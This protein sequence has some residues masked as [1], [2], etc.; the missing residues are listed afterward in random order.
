[1]NDQTVG[2]TE[3]LSE[4]LNVPQVD[5]SDHKIP[6]RLISLIPCDFA[7]K[8]RCVPFK[9]MGKTLQV[10]MA[11]PTNISV[12]DDLKFMTGYE[13]EPLITSETALESAIERYYGD[14]QSLAKAMEDMREEELELVEDKEEEEID[15]QKLHIAV[16]E[17]PVV[18]FVDSL[19][20]DA[21]RKGASDIHI[22]PYESFLRVRTR[23]DGVLYELPSPPAKL[24]NA[25][26]SRVK[27]MANLDLAER[28]VPQDGHIKMKLAAKTIDLRV[29]TL[30]TI[31]GEKV[32]MRILDRTAISLD[33][34][35][36]GFEEQG[37][38]NFLTA[39]Q[40]PYG[41]VLVTGPTGSGK[42]TTLYSALS[43]INTPKTN[44]MT[45]EDPIEYNFAG[46]NQL[47]VKENIGLTFS[48]AL[49]AFLRQD[50]DIIMVGE[51]RDLETAHI[52]IRAALT[53]H[54]VL[55][56]LHTND[57]PSTISRIL[58]MGVE[59]FLITS[60]LNLVVAQRLMRRICNHCKEE[61][62]VH[63]E[64]FRELEIE[65]DEM[66]GVAFYKG[67]GCLECNNSGY[68]GREGIFEVMPITNEIKEL[69]L[70]RRPI[71]EIAEVAHDSGMLTLKEAAMLKLKRGITTVEEV[72]RVIKTFLE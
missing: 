48:V 56:T 43:R 57:A 1:M 35:K 65:P 14:T 39:I 66:A 54:L 49:R 58:D 12:L 7:R 53:G 31:Y 63:P 10:V 18:R 71:S 40:A 23:I 70:S 72:A 26:I 36:L 47:Q 68:K 9:K 2:I 3:T 41:L 11:D 29:S 55:S 16:Q 15:L 20:A 51:I 27:V 21:V 52:A 8:Y 60:S 25:I 64:V 28:R 32:V 6:D 45:A 4:K 69:V 50:P 61:A 17:A 5:L 33:L 22:E 34:E 38:K 37:L 30:P 13:I 46:I 59:P 24:K 19:I 44:I 42:T 67:K 62:S